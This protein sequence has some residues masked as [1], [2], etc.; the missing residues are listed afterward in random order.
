MRIKKENG[1][2]STMKRTDMFLTRYLLH[3]EK[4]LHLSQTN[5]VPSSRL[6][7]N[8]ILV[9]HVVLESDNIRE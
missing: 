5:N 2:W 7:L 4:L 8:R 3:G 1:R 6:G 9:E